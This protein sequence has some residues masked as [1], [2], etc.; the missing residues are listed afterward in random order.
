MEIWE[1]SNKKSRQRYSLL[2]VEFESPKVWCIHITYILQYM[3]IIIIIIVIII[4]IIINTSFWFTFGY[5][6][7]I[8]E[9]LFLKKGPPKWQFFF[10]HQKKD[11]SAPHL[12]RYLGRSKLDGFGVDGFGRETVH[13]SPKV[14]WQFDRNFMFFLNSRETSQL[15]RKNSSAMN[16]FCHLL[17]RCTGIKSVIRNGS[18]RRDRFRKF[19]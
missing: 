5:S 11:A 10:P 13:L 19:R 3:H 7:P 18:P 15:P 9:D 6:H 12:S 16:L 8:G 17:S 4:I 1:N 14:L 2:K